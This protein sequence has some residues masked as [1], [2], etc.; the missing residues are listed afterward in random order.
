MGTSNSALPKHGATPL[1]RLSQKSLAP[2]D[3]F[4]HFAICRRW[5]RRQKLADWRS[6]ENTHPERRELTL[7]RD[8]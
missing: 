1:S 8:W 6:P 5:R 4:R 7:P 3:S 2:Q